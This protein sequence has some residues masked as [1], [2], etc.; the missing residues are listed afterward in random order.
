VIHVVTVGVVFTVE[1][2]FLLCKKYSR[3]EG[4]RVDTTNTCKTA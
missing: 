3:H 4:Y 2:S 1:S